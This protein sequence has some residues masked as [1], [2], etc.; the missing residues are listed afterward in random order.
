MFDELDED[1]TELLRAWRNGDDQALN[2][3][4]AVVVTSFGRVAR[5]HLRREQAGHP[6]QATALVHEVYIRLVNVDQMTIENRAH[7]LALAARLM[8]QISWTTLDASARRSAAAIVRSCPS[9]T[10]QRS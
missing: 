3:L 7:F 5:V 4:M 6:L 8:R 10:R 1:V 2:R 9:A